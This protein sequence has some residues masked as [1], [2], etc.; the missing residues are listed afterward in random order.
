MVRDLLAA[1]R[2]RLLS[3]SG[4]LGDTIRSGI[5][6]GATTVASRTFELTRLIA[7][8]VLLSPE[9][10]GVMGIALLTMASFEMLTELG[11]KDALI[12]NEEEDVDEYLDTAWLMNTGRGVAIFGV[13]FLLAPYIST[14][15]S[16]PR[17]TPVI[18]AIGLMPLL[19]GLQNPAIVYFEKDLNFHQH[20]L[21][22]VS[23]SLV[24]AVA[25][26]GF[27]MVYGTVWALVVGYL[28]AR[29]TELVVSY[30]LTTRRPGISFDLDKAA[31]LFGYGKWLT[32][33]SFLV[34]LGTQG[35][36]AFL[37]WFLGAGALGVYQVAYRIS[38]APATEVGLLV[39]KVVFP[40]YSKV[41]DDIAQIRSGFLSVLVVVSVITFP[42]T[43]GTVVVAPTFVFGIQG[44]QW[45][46][47]VRP[48]QV[49]ALWG[50]LRAIGSITGPMFKA[51]GRPDVLTKVAFV[52]TAIMAALIY[53]LTAEFGV[54]GTALAVLV[55][56][57]AFSEPVKYYL[58]IKEVNI[59]WR[60]LVERMFVP[61]VASLLMGIGVYIVR[62]RIQ[63]AAG[64]P[65]LALLILLG[66][67]LY[68]AAVALLERRFD[69]GLQSL[70]RT[71]MS[72]MA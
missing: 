54:V 47:A 22:K 69:Y 19:F 70:I 68:V 6:M 59:T 4:V 30:L 1:V 7:L 42:M 45:A 71:V 9:E 33:L 37:G 20:F 72:S 32:G 2:D 62:E 3:S 15:F 36:D 57:V 64:V 46:D 21:H 56:S 17:A 14:F 50:L 23:G 8:T 66:V 35:D 5:W 63:L 53:P 11:I 16:E 61:L 28:S 58:A 25:A 55:S 48:I 34:F 41:Q 10:F 67:G 31:E 43:V 44:Q 65:K 18:R 12:Y 49:L 39:S 51:I 60:Q 29:T 27:A 52:K 13:V 24:G 26:I 40:A 38:N